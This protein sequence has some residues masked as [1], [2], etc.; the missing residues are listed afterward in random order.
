MQ[1]FVHQQNHPEP[2][3]RRSALPRPTTSRAVRRSLRLRAGGELPKCVCGFMFLSHIYIYTPNIIYE[4]KKKNNDNKSSNNN[5]NCVFSIVIRVSF[6]IIG[7]TISMIVTTK[8][9]L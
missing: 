9:L 2:R 3:R 5:K 7:T 1:D 6:M 4:D 8:L